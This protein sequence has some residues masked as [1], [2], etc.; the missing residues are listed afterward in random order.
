MVED[1]LQREEA[2]ETCDNKCKTETRLF[3]GWICV[4]REA[5]TRSSVAM[6]SP[7]GGSLEG[8]GFCSGPVLCQ[9]DVTLQ[10]Q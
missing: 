1:T 8:R 4:R 5:T 7:R 3:V 6:V 2:Y 9:E 10:Q